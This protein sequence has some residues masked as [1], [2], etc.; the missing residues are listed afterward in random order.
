MSN[1]IFFTVLGILLYD[2]ER[3]KLFVKEDKA[4]AMLS[5]LV[6]VYLFINDYPF[7]LIAF[8]AS[9]V[10]IRYSDIL[11][12]YLKP[13][14]SKSQILKKL[15]TNLKGFNVPIENSEPIEYYLNEEDANSILEEIDIDIWIDETNEWEET[16]WMVRF[17]FKNLIFGI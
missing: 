5:G 8:I 3:F 9:F 11:D 10:A 1:I 16:K 7:P 13:Y 4:I 12:R 6:L 2:D 17:G 15:Y 14:T